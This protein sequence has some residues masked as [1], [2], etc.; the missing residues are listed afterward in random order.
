V[1]Q[2][3]S[4][5]TASRV[6][7]LALPGEVLPVLLVLEP[8]LVGHPWTLAVSRAASTVQVRDV[9]G[10]IHEPGVQASVAFA[11]HCQDVVRV[12]VCGEG[13]GLPSG[14]AAASLVA[15]AHALGQLL[16]ELAPGAAR[17]PGVER[18]WW[19]TAASRTFILLAEGLFVPLDAHPLFEP[20]PV[21]PLGAGRAA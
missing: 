21:L 18:L 1:L 15:R 17:L 16:E 9:V 3:R 6:P 14:F 10:A 8:T 13:P 2:Y 12:F 5:F 4:A 20:L 7:R 11:L 19:D